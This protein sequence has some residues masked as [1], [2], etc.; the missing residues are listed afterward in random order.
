MDLSYSCVN[1][2]CSFPGA[3]PFEMTFKSESIMDENNVASLFCPFCGNELILVK[4]GP[5]VLPENLSKD[6]TI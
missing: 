4:G 2:N 3:N 5:D 1:H 6:S